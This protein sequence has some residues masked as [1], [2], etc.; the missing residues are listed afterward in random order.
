VDSRPPEP[1]RAANGSPELRRDL[2]LGDRLVLT[3]RRFRQRSS[4]REREPAPGRRAEQCRQ[5]SNVRRKRRCA[6]LG[7]PETPGW[8]AQHLGPAH[9]HGPVIRRSGRTGALPQ[10]RAKLRQDRVVGHPDHRAVGCG[11]PDAVYPDSAG[12]AVYR[13]PRVAHAS[14]D[15]PWTRARSR[16]GP[17]GTRPE[18]LRGSL[19]RTFP[20]RSR[21]ARALPSPAHMDGPEPSASDPA[22]GM[23]AQ[24]PACPWDA[25]PRAFRVTGHRLSRFAAALRTGGG[26]CD[27]RGT[28]PGH[29]VD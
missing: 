1:S 9:D 10:P 25:W 20:R 27:R 17:R 16:A 15:E 6:V 19:D 23:V 5:A 14:R 24:Q 21:R 28:E 2:L 12:I 18:P 4:T 7:L 11:R 8:S 22:Q 13:V 26:F 3:R 29:I